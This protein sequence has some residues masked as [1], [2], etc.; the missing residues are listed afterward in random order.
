MAAIITNAKGQTEGK[1]Q[2]NPRDIPSNQRGMYSEVPIL[3][4]NS[5]RRIEKS[6][7]NGTKP[8]PL[9]GPSKTNSRSNLALLL[10]STRYQSGVV[11]LIKINEISRAACH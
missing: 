6:K 3:R 7:M 9:L 4:S 2:C 10:C 8:P 1:A 5:P 11:V